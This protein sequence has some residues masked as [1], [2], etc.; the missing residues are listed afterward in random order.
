MKFINRELEPVIA[1]AIRNFPS[2]VLTGPP[3]AGKTHLLRHLF[4]RASYFLLEDP[5]IVSRLRGDPHGFLDAVAT[6]AIL[7]QVQ[8]VPE[9]FAH[10]RARIDRQPRRVGQWI[11]TGSQEAPLMRNVTESMAGR[12]AV[13]Q[14]LPFSFRETPKVTPLRGGFPEVIARPVAATLWFSSFLQTYLERDVRAVTGVRD[15][16]TFRRFIGLLASRHGQMLNKTNLAAPLGV[17]VPTIT[18]WLQRAR[19]DSANP[20]CAAVLRK[21]GQTLGQE[22]QGLYRGPRSGVSLARN[23]VRR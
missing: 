4:P 19:S 21:H 17:S 15:L 22:P 6:P 5:D 23:R 10:V 11:L 2:V 1:K 3:A 7:D 16:A 13:L 9:V 8:N 14:L 12:A 20:G 18:Q